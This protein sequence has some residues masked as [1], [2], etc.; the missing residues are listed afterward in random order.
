M[1][2]V[3]IEGG[4]ARA[5]LRGVLA[6]DVARLQQP[7]KALY[8]CMLAQDGGV[9]DDLIAYYLRDNWYRVVVNAG[10]A[11][12]DLQWLLAQRDRLAREV[13]VQPRRDLAIVAVQGPQARERFWQVRPDA[14][15][16][17]EPLVY[18]QAAQAGELFVARS[19]YTGEDGFEVMLPAGQAERLWADLHHAG[20]APC[21][22]GARDT[23]RLEAGMNLYGQD[24][25]RSVTPMEAGLAWTVSMA[26]ER[27]FV[28]RQAL[29]RRIPR[30]QLLGLVLDGKGVLRSHQPVRCAH[31]NGEITSG[32]FSPTLGRAIALARLPLA[33]RI[34][35]AVEVQIRDKWL[36]AQAVKYPFVR[37]GKSLLSEADRASRSEDPT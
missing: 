37:H 17:T 30:F 7:G 12:S 23:L 14:R 10:T 2:A 32:T 6:N 1:L 3:D 31:G 13:K 8:S 22:L 4:D 21:G 11:D 36:P 20:V 29:E 16:T 15:A 5:L 19:G 35:D 33:V 27:N 26:D 34:G 25:D 24:M 18:F 9:L 28:G